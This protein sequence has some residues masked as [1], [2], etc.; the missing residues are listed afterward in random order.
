MIPEEKT[1]SGLVIIHKESKMPSFGII[2]AMGPGVT[3]EINIGDKIIYSK[4]AGLA[5]SEDDK[6]YLLIEESECIA[7]IEG[8]L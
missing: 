8:N 5:I 1:E 7:K 2:R 6:E 3:L 4:F